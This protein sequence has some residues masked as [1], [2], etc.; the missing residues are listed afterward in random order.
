M[1]LLPRAI[2]LTTAAAINPYQ[3]ARVR[4]VITNAATHTPASMLDTAD[5]KSMPNRKAT[6]TPVQ[7]PVPGKGT[8]TNAANPD[9]RSFSL[10]ALVFF[11]ARARR[12]LKS[13]FTDGTRKASKNGGISSMLPKMHNAITWGTESPIHSPTGMPP[14]SST[15]GRADTAMRISQS[16]H[17]VI[18]R[19]PRAIFCPRCSFPSLAAAAWAAIGQAMEVNTNTSPAKRMGNLRCALLR[20]RCCGLAIVEDL[21]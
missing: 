14:R 2:M 3:P 8:P 12:G 1:Y 5:V 11:S 13:R 19:K 10:T 9:Q 6:M 7:A 15:K 4:P 20:D 16:G 21:C 18:E 17:P